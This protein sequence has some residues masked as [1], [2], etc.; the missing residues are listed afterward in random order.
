MKYIISYYENCYI[1]VTKNSTFEGRGNE[2]SATKYTLKN[3]IKDRIKFGK[4]FPNY[5]KSPK[6]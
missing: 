3:N 2:I 1:K 6:T 4:E 5:K